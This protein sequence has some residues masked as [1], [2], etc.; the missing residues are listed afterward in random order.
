MER[1]MPRQGEDPRGGLSPRAGIL[2]LQPE[3]VWV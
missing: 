2:L 3:G 1:V